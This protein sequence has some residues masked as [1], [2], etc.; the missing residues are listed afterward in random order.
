MNRPIIGCDLDD[1][2]AD[3]MGVFIG[4][5]N[6]KFAIPSDTSLRPIDWEWSNMGWSPE[7]MKELWADVA[8]TPNFWTTLPLLKGVNPD[9]VSQLNES[10]ELYFPTARAH[11]IGDPVSTQCARWLLNK[12]SIPFPRVIVSNEKGPLADA[13]KYDYFIDD[14]GKNCADVKAA[15]P[16]CRV[17]LVEASHN[18]MLDTASIGVERVSGINEFT[19]IVLSQL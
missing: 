12:F 7:H 6:A 3:F 9:K 18:K 15:R 16:E 10:T 1:V 17:Y 14:R 2:L 11:C 13:L 4:M 19:D 8:N 5:A